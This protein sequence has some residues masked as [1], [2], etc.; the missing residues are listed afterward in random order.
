MA[1]ADMAPAPLNCPRCLTALAARIEDCAVPADCEIASAALD[2]CLV[3]HC[4]LP[5]VDDCALCRPRTER[6]RTLCQQWAAAETCDRLAMVVF[7]DCANRCEAPDCPD[8]CGDC[9]RAAIPPAPCAAVAPTACGPALV[10][11]F[12]T[13]R[14]ACEDT[15]DAMIA[16]AYRAGARH[17]LCGGRGAECDRV[18]AMLVESCRLTG[19][20]GPCAACD[21]RRASEQMACL[22][23]GFDAA[24]CG[25]RDASVGAACEAQCAGDAITVCTHTGR[26]VASNCEASG[27][28]RCGDLAAVVSSHCLGAAG[29]AVQPCLGCLTTALGAA[30]GCVDR[31]PEACLTAIEEPWNRCL[32]GCGE[33]R[34]GGGCLAC[35]FEADRLL[36]RCLAE[37]GAVPRCFAARAAAETVCLG[38]CGGVRPEA[39]PCAL[40]G[41]LLGERCLAVEPVDALCIESAARLEAACRFVRGE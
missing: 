24:I 22:A 31:A 19:V 3:D 38:R 10:E 9:L 2:T 7:E 25:A 20:D 21:S 6:L 15:A 40:R 11:R 14:P 8:C 36:G 27:G 34:S 1:P 4:A 39:L 23:V 41:R 12:A 30:G 35:G 28:E 18:L 29:I 33:M 17:A 13:C 5:T 37:G 32:A 16:C 26:L